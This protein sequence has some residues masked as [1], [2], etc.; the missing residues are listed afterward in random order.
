MGTQRPDW[1]PITGSSA[2]SSSGDIRALALLGNIADPEDRKVVA[3]SAVAWV[4]ASRG[5]TYR[6]MGRYEEAL[7]DF[8]RAIELDPSDDDYAAK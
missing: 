7:T 1:P 3:L 8:N 6:L 5:E 2:R 4:I